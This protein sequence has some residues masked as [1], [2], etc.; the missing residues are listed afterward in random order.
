M[1]Q[2]SMSDGNQQ[3][4]SIPIGD[5][6]TQPMPQMALGSTAFASSATQV[7]F[8]KPCFGCGYNLRGLN[9]E[10]KCPECGVAIEKSM[11]GFLLRFASAEY[12]SKIHSG[13][14]LILAGII[15]QILLGVT[16]AF[17]GIAFSAAGTGGI[18]GMQI[19][20]NFIGLAITVVLILGYWRFTEPDPG[21][22]GLEQPQ[23]ARQ[24]ARIAVIASAVVAALQFVL[25]FFLSAGP[26]GAGTATGVGLVSLLV[27]LAG[28]VAWA[29][30]F[31]AIMLYLRWLASRVPDEK[32]VKRTKTYMWLL[33]VLATVGAILL[34]LGPLV[35]LVLYWNLLDRF[36]KHLKAIR[37]GEMR[38][39]V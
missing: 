26:G 15:A 32:I 8:D 27:G 36:R 12:L 5:H 14:F 33:P 18:G 23:S 6:P 35:A 28:L 37:A 1:S 11:Q 39:A 21:F 9:I 4:D 31:F 3:P 25:A 24:V 17:V 22:T 38:A 10:G 7:G 19:L 30:Q 29:V 20:M 16:A 13:V 2:E 34:L